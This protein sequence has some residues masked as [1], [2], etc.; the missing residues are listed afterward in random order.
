MTSK[1]AT[2]Q[3][4]VPGEKLKEQKE[5]KKKPGKF[6]PIIQHISKIH[7][8]MVVMRIGQKRK[9]QCF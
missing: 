5:K 1:Q 7:L 9:L 3:A 8:N 4:S 2:E 6:S